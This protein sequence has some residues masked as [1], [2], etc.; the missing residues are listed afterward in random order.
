M[1][2]RVPD[3]VEGELRKVF[4]EADIGGANLST[5]DSAAHMC[6]RRVLGRR[7]LGGYDYK[8]AWP[9]VRV[10]VLPGTADER[11]FVFDVRELVRQG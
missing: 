4:E 5:V 2:Q 3:E 6:I 7:G 11:A 8:Y 1:A 9:V 10:T